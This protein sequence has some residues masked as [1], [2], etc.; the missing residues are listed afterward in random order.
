MKSNEKRGILILIVVVLIIVAILHGI[1]KQNNNEGDGQLVQLEGFKLSDVDVK[2][3]GG[4]TTLIANV[5]NKTGEDKGIIPV[6][7]V[8]L[9]EEKNELGRIQAVVTETKS[10]QTIQIR[11]STPKDFGEAK[12]YVL[13]KK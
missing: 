2:T 5:T 1:L 13:V 12:E 3:E 4:K 6:Y 8:L 11:T 10:G 9:G 7:I